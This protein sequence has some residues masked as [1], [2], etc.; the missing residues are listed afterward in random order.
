MKPAIF[1]DRDGTI[2]V[3][4]NYLNDENLVEF[5]PDAIA[6]LKHLQDM[7]FDLIVVTNQSGVARGLVSE[8]N[9]HKIH[10]RMDKELANYKVKI[11]GYYYSPHAA[12]SN[13]PT[14]KPN[15]GMIEQAILEHKIDRTK[16][17]MIGDKAIDVG[18]GINAKVKTIF[19]STATESSPE[20][21]TTCATLREAAAYIESQS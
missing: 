18:A 17:W 5:L 9:L 20:A 3:D 16:S 2:I 10:N 8:D 11:K 13:H 1:L 15:P 14:R 6:G 7:G 21:D 19:I 4:K 12:D